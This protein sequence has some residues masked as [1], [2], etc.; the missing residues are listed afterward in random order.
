[1]NFSRGADA[2]AFVRDLMTF[3]ILQL[4]EY[5]LVHGDPH[6]GNIGR[7]ADGRVV[8]YDFGNVIRLSRKERHLVKELVYLLIVRN[9]YAVAKLLP[10]LGVQVGNVEDLHNYIDKYV[11]YMETI[12]YRTLQK[13]YK[14][15]AELPVKL[16]GKVLRIV[17][18][19]GTLEGLCKELDPDFN[20]FQLL[21]AYISV[22]ALDEDFLVYKIDQD[23]KRL[24]Q[25]PN[26][27]FKA[28]DVMGDL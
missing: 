9:K 10:S 19:F 3:F 1:M 24:Q 12:D 4:L 28:L 15:N 26:A 18:A 11:E 17:K 6:P 20:Y 2:K 8:V 13:L 22:A 16:E 14:P 27:L 23:V 21:D 7:S 5:G 25:W